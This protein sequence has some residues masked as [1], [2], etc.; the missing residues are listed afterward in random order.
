M[1][2][3]KTNKK[4]EWWSYS[5]P[6]LTTIFVLSQVTLMIR[7]WGKFG[8][9]VY[10]TTPLIIS[11]LAILFIFIGIIYS[12]VKR[13]FMQKNR[14]IW[15]FCLALFPLSFFFRLKQQGNLINSY[16]S[17]HYKKTSKI[18]YRIPFDTIVSV[19][20]GG[21]KVEHN[22]HVIAPDQR[23]AYDIVIVKNNTSYVGDSSKLENYFI[24]GLPILSPADGEVVKVFDSIPDLKIREELGIVESAKN[25][26]G[27]YVMIKTDTNEYLVLCHIKPKTTKVKVGEK[28]K[29]GQEI[30]SV[31]NSGNTSEP[32]LH[33]HL[34][35]SKNLDFAEG[36]PL[37]F[38]NYRTN[39]KLVKMGMPTGGIK[40][41]LWI[42]QNIQ[43]QNQ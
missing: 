40:D 21:D 12:I 9:I 2:Q 25:A 39:G 37:Y 38:H 30:G 23:W 29:Q 13:P 11:V 35:D 36:I 32:H 14:I 7:V 15:L 4:I 42:G 41:T 19:F 34:Q 10:L 24:Y 20:W 28:V 16:P 17:S 18:N 3:K 6:I 8:P 43:H 33:I 22:Y 5:F 1:E 26:H 27:N 31:G